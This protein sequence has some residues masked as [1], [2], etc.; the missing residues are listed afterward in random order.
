M[1]EVAPPVGRLKVFVA[2]SHADV[3]VADR[4]VDGLRDRYGFEVSH[5][6]QDFSAGEN[7]RER[8]SGLIREADTIVFLL[9]PSS[10]ASSICQWEVDV[11]VSLGKRIVPV[12]LGP[13]G[14][15][16]APEQLRQLNYIYLYHE[17]SIPSTRTGNR[18]LRLADAL[19]VDADWHRVGTQLLLRALD[20]EKNGRADASLLQS[21]GE[22]HFFRTWAATRLSGEE[23][24]VHSQT[25]YIDA[26][27]Q[28]LVRLKHE[29]ALEKP[30]LADLPAYQRLRS[31]I[32]HLEQQY[33]Q[34]LQLNLGVPPNQRLMT[35]YLMMLCVVGWVPG[36]ANIQMLA[37]TFSSVVAYS[38]A[39]I[40]AFTLSWASHVHGQQAKQWQFLL[41]SGFGRVKLEHARVAQTSWRTKHAIASAALISALAFITYAPYRA[42]PDTATVIGLVPVVSTNIA[43]WFAGSV[44]SW[45]WHERVPELR[46]T[47]ARL[48]SA[49]RRLMALR[50]GQSTEIKFGKPGQ[51]LKLWLAVAFQRLA[52][53]RGRLRVVAS[54]A[55]V[56]FPISL[57]GLLQ[58]HLVRSARPIENPALDDQR[59]VSALPIPHPARAHPRAHAS[60]VADLAVAPDGKTFA[61]VA[62]DGM[63]TLWDL[64]SGNA[65]WSKSGLGPNDL[66]KIGF[67]EV[68]GRSA[69]ARLQR[70]QIF[71]YEFVAITDGAVIPLAAEGGATATLEL[72]NRAAEA[73]DRRNT[74]I[75]SSLMRTEVHREIGPKLVA[76]D[77]KSTRPNV[78]D[79]TT[80]INAFGDGRVVSRPV[81]CRHNRLSRQLMALKCVRWR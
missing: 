61:T 8:L 23:R 80:N 12:A 71:P 62:R 67:I 15:I 46:E 37:Q 31:E 17:P 35:I 66:R 45:W 19:E 30:E 49:Q 74:G 21:L 38:I 64:A 42:T 75:A 78:S 43:A 68:E 29:L 10:I 53:Y 11:A 52:P 9:S 69:L 32:A 65:Q 25:A 13:L 33:Q 51:S 18:L 6:R 5:F 16:S 54:T 47:Y 3:E 70:D 2:Y 39:S 1:A 7:F 79:V 20:W 57:A 34:C 72:S 27:E 63:L 55:L 44:Y 76:L 41:L 26:S 24:P 56:L 48:Q 58:L 73:I 60:A 4:V 50:S 81:G 22:V 59:L 40:V 14:S 36:I 28:R 77:G